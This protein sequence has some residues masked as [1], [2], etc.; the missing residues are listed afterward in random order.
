[1]FFKIL[2]IL[3]LFFIFN[4]YFIK[5]SYS[6]ILKKIEISGNDRISTET[7]A[8]FSEVKI[9]DKVNSSIIN[10]V[11]KNLYNTNFFKDVSIKFTNNILEIK[12]VENPIIQNITY[13]GIKSNRIKDLIVSG[14]K[15]K[16]RSSFNDLILRKDKER[17]K[18]ELKNLGYYFPLIE[19]Y[20]EDLKDNKII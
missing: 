20:I 6:D 11:L 14:T 3:C 17:I 1:M 18:S 10:N 16:S 9:N 5:F 13:E 12:V 2:R 4:L 7:I 8:M 15:L 19:T